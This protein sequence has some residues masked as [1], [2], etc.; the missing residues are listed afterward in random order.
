MQHSHRIDC[1]A[2]SDRLCDT[3]CILEFSPRRF[4]RS[5]DASGGIPVLLASGW[6]PVGLKPRKL[7]YLDQIYHKRDQCSICWLLFQATHSSGEDDG[8]GYDGLN[9]DDQ[10]VECYVSWQPD[11]RFLSA[12][13]EVSPV[14][15][16]LRV[17]NPEG[18]FPEAYIMLSS[19]DTTT[20][21]TSPSFLAPQ[22][23]CKCRHCLQVAGSLPRASR[24]NLQ[25]PLNRALMR[26]DHFQPSSAYRPTRELS[27]YV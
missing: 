25:I 19:G 22:E 26:L 16:R 20:R 18:L 13:E 1:E 5:R 21:D 6:D 7:G 15:R 2:P 9:K 11:G 10:R 8:I 24:R 3:C 17:F 27:S 23:P 14:T 4:V 12:D